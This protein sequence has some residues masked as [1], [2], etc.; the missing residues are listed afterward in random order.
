MTEKQELL[1]RAVDDAGEEIL[2]AER[3]LWQHPQTGYTEWQA[4]EY[5]KEKFEALGYELT[6]AGDIPGFIADV[7]TGR[8]GPKVVI[9]GELD[10]LEQKGHPCAVDGMAHSCG[11]NAQG[12]ALL[13]IA[14]ALKA[15]GALDGL[16]GSI[17]LCAVPA[18]EM[19]QLS[20]REE[21]RKKGTIRYM[22]GKPEFMAR[23]LL[24][25]VDIAMMVHAAGGDTKE[26]PFDFSCG[27]GQNGCMAKTIVYKGRAAHAGGA[28]HHGINAEY[29]ATLGLS[30]CNA[31]RETFPDRDHIR[32]HPILMGAQCAVNIIPDEM[33]I[34]SYVRGA[35]Q[36]AIIRENRKIN[37]ALAGAALA[38]GAQVELHDRPGY[39]P[40]YHDPAL[41][42]L[43]EECCATLV[44]RQHVRFNYEDWGMAS[45]DFGDITSVMPG[46]QFHA[47]GAVGIGHGVNFAIAEPERLCLNAA[48]A[49]LLLAEALLCE[50][51]CAAKKIIAEYKPAYASIPEYLAAID[52]MILDKEAVV[53][54]TDGTATVDFAND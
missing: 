5:L 28:P 50:D 41:M 21:L 47:T 37:R 24:D 8:P 16:C 54:N 13:G 22:G 40:E 32:F 45:S 25:G 30:A 15:P 23:G 11:H 52:R 4:H 9:F 38:M 29:A 20:F 14:M 26:N 46:V 19:I 1:V 42:K 44:G 34:E 51:A 35:T 12:A 6:P 2:A 33:R 10:A 27:K 53:Y 31:L 17:R 18:E 39:A 3:W 36:Q 43:T 48:K 7:D 49:Q